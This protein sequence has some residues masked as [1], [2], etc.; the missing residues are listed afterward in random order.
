MTFVTIKYDAPDT[1]TYEAVCVSPSN[2]EYDVI[3]NSGDP[4]IDWYYHNKYLIFNIPDG[5]DVCNSST[6]DHFFMDGAMV[7][8][9]YLLFDESG[10]PY[11]GKSK[12]DSG[13]EFLINKGDNITWL[14]LREYCGDHFSQFDINLKTMDI[15]EVEAVKAIT[16]SNDLVY[17]NKM[18]ECVNMDMV[19]I[20]NDSNVIRAMKAKIWGITVD[21]M[22]LRQYK[23]FSGIK[24]LISKRIAELNG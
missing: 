16:K 8:S 6:I 19:R 10:T 13:V 23:Y 22:E 17:L 1:L 3:F 12:N 11:L 9:T 24:E 7:E 5:D 4:V 18:N 15:S 2:S 20:S 21:E 14:E